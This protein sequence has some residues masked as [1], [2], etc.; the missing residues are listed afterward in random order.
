MSLNAL[1]RA[2][3]S[4]AEIVRNISAWHNIPTRSAKWEALPDDLHPKL[5]TMLRRHGINQLYSHQAE[6]LRAI[7][8][9]CHLIV[10]TGTAS[11]KTLC[12]NLPILDRLLKEPDARAL[13]LYPTKA[14]A[15]DQENNLLSLFGLIDG[16]NQY[17]D[18]SQISAA[19]YDGDTL[20]HTRSSIRS[21]ARLVL[22]NPD[23]LHAGILPHHTIWS[24]LF[25]ALRFV[26]IDEMHVYRGVFGSHVAN[27]IRRLKRVSSFYG[28]FPQFI[29]TS[30]SIANPEELAR[31]L[32]ET[33]NEPQ[34]LEYIDND[35]SALGEKIFIIYNPPIVNKDLG[36]RRSAIQESIRLASD[37][38]SYN[39]Q[40]IL[41]ARSRRS[42]ELLLTYLR[43]QSSTS[44]SNHPLPQSQNSNVEGIRGYRSGYLPEHRREIEQGLRQGSVK[45][46]VA[47][48]A[49]EL[50][51][52]IGG[53]GAAIMIGYPGTIAS[54]WQQAGRAGRGESNS[55]ALLIASADPLD[56]FLASHSEYFF[57]RSP[58]QALINAD[59]LLILLAHIRCATFELPFQHGE[60][61]GNVEPTTLEE[62]LNFLVEEG[63][64]HRSGTKYFW[65][66]DFY[67]S[68]RISLRS[69]S[70][71]NIVLQEINETHRV[72]G[73]VDRASAS[74]MVH[75]Q[76]IYLHEGQTYIVEDLDLENSIALLRRTET[77][78][79]TVHQSNS[80]VQLVDLIQGRNVAGGT[81]NYGNVI[82]FTLYF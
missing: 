6:S 43:Q 35:G 5:E 80:V 8:K 42:V 7:R 45:A 41:F 50:G 38:L 52:N 58:E 47:T 4:N 9:G 61:F 68:Q 78:Y 66:A 71:N 14:L 81:I 62:I 21:N 10:A 53:L 70:P 46:V 44:S 37:L 72:I 48:N 74:W 63:S 26:V 82:P 24:Q 39:V 33:E 49:L 51:I 77:D 30:A 36:L 22:S 67:P 23:M 17:G 64:L 16:G 40:T 34:Q 18:D 19:I 3:K 12:Y 13:Y 27:V 28:S 75:P 1:L 55:I 56:Q 20:S 57:S 59:N 11:G 79:Y 69:T 31:K 73:Q 15:Q 54:T 76:A 29:L 60:R 65:L 25:H 32:I 2:W